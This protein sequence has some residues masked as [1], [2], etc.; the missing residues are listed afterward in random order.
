MLQDHLS[1]VKVTEGKNT[2]ESFFSQNFK[3]D[4]KNQTKENIIVT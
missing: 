4:E 1:N 2:C 3:K